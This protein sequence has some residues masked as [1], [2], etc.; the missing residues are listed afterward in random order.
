MAFS[1][2]LGYLVVRG[3]IH[4]PL[5]QIELLTGQEVL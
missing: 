1:L 3:S 4:I 5:T 2:S